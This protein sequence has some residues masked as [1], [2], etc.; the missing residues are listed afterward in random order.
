MKKNVVSIIAI[1]LI[2]CMLCVSLVSCGTVLSG[3]YSGEASFFGL[4]GGTATYEFSGKKVTLTVT[5]EVLGF[6]KTS[7]PIEGEYSIA[8]KE[9]GTQTITFSF[10]EDGGDEYSGTFAF[11][12]GDNFIEISGTKFYKK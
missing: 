4:V 5:T 11:A 2:V 6:S 3:T 10:G 12:K 9:D 1:A 7:D 8:E